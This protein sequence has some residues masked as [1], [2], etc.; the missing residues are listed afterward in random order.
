M[1]NLDE[2][3]LENEMIWIVTI[4][5]LNPIIIFFY[6]NFFLD[7]IFSLKTVF[8]LLIQILL[9]IHHCKKSKYNSIKNKNKNQYNFFNLY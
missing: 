7:K 1:N 5:I 2:D 8:F 4:I 3:L 6:L 9:K